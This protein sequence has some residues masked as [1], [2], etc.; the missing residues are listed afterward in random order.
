MNKKIY[1]GLIIIVIILIGMGGF[2]LGIKYQE[3]KDNNEKNENT[4]I[5]DNNTNENIL[6]NNN[7]NTNISDEDMI[8]NTLNTSSD[9]SSNLTLVPATL[10]GIVENVKNATIKVE[11]LPESEI[12]YKGRVEIQINEDTQILLNET[13]IKLTDI[14]EGNKVKVTFTGGIAL[15]SPAIVDG[16][17]K[18]EIIE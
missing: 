1:I 9:T 7:I 18:I 5:N 3:L 11:N 14:K 13:E 2:L 12:S 15:T 10:K 17:Q 16:V 8:T 4:T 6:S